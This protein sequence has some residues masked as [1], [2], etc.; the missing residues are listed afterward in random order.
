MSAQGPAADPDRNL[1][2]LSVDQLLAAADEAGSPASETAKSDIGTSPATTQRS[3]N[4]VPLQRET[5]VQ[6]DADTAASRPVPARK[7]KAGSYRRKVAP[8]A[9]ALKE[10]AQ[11]RYIADMRAHF[12]EVR[13]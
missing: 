3:E 4:T 6:R 5:A 8:G 11:A 10:A 13:S 7:G 2:E 9:M 1:T 12:D